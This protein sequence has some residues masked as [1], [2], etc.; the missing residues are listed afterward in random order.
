MARPHADW[1][2]KFYYVMRMKYRINGKS[3]VP[4]YSLP[5]KEALYLYTMID[6][7]M[8]TSGSGLIVNVELEYSNILDNVDYK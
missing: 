7:E 4:D 8:I 1:S 3:F 2:K 6:K 5:E